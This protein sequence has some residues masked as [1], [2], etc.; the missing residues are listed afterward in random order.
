MAVPAAIS[1]QQYISSLCYSFQCQM[2]IAT[3]LGTESRLFLFSNWEKHHHDRLKLLQI[4]S[5]SFSSRFV[6][7][8]ALLWWFMNLSVSIVYIRLLCHSVRFMAIVKCFCT[9][10]SH[11]QQHFPRHIIV[12]AIRKMVVSRRTLTFVAFSRVERYK[13]WDFHLR[14]AY[15]IIGFLVLP[16]RPYSLP[17][18]IDVTLRVQTLGDCLFFF[19]AE[20]CTACGR[21]CPVQ[22]SQLFV[23]PLWSFNTVITI[24]WF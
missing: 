12:T 1:K 19:V 15:V 13:K 18:V 3:D 2:H 16:S 11:S 23:R 9:I 8:K 4:F 21:L 20:I 14:L 10:P 7:F 24:E 17:D 5:R 22:T 6:Y